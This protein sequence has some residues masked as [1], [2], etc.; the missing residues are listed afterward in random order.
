MSGM[1]NGAVRLQSL[2]LGL[3]LAGGACWAGDL[4]D[5]RPMQ[6]GSLSAAAAEAMRGSLPLRVPLDGIQPRMLVDSFADRRAGERQHEALDILAARGTPVHAVDDG[7]V[8]KLFHSKPGGLT[9]YQFDPRAI[10]AYY[11]A[12]LDRYAD[13]L[14]EGQ[15][16]Q[17]GDLLG[18]VGSTGN[19]DPSTPHLHFAVF[20][21]GPG[22]QWWKG[23]AIN[24]LA[25]MSA[26]PSPRP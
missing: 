8:I 20:E 1:R 18:Y 2:V 17:R 23:R 4:P 22:R 21:L 19:A 24:P 26:S 15:V 12:H 6:P 5:P 13:G 25:L 10:L 14:A 9:I 7:T 16:V 3:V 11:Y